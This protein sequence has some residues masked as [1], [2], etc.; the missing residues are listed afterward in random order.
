[1][2]YGVICTTYIPCSM[3]D[4]HSR[5]AQ[6]EDG[7]AHTYGLS[8]VYDMTPTTQYVEIGSLVAPCYIHTYVYMCAKL[9]LWY[10]VHQYGSVQV[11]I[12][13]VLYVVQDILDI[14]SRSAAVLKLRVV[15]S[16]VDVIPYTGPVCPYCG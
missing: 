14:C 15:P 11:Y 12:P 2:Y 7:L 5:S 16:V 10:I 13:T 1:M 4:A 6:E 9:G 3:K 8:T